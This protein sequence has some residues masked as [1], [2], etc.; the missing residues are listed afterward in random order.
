LPGITRAFVMD[1]A[2]AQA[3]P[4]RE[5]RIVPADLA[6]VQ[7][8]FITGTTREVTP[9]VAVGAQPVGTGEPGPVTQRLLTAFRAAIPSR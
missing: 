6:S 2:K 8:A 4:C 7:E 9:V 5:A 3:I 1:L